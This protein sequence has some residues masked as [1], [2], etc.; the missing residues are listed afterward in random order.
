MV[1][2]ASSN[3][4]QPPKNSWKAWLKESGSRSAGW[5]QAGT[6][7]CTDYNSISVA[8]IGIVKKDCV[9]RSDTARPSLVIAAMKWTEKSDQTP[10]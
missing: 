10:P 2:I 8:I 7:I 1:D 9:I 3:S 5:P 6:S 4:R